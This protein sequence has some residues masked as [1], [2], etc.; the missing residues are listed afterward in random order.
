MTSHRISRANQVR[1]PDDNLQER[2]TS[3]ASRLWLTYLV[4]MVA[5]LVA[6][7]I[8]SVALR[9]GW[10]VWAI[11]LLGVAVIGSL[12]S[13]AVVPSIRRR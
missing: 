12:M 3:P 6:A 1:R 10:G 4:I 11:M 5:L 9:G 7:G 13:L 8:V 2:R